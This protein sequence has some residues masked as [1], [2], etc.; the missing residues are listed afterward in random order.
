MKVFEEFILINLPKAYLEGYDIIE[1]SL[2]TK[3]LPLSPKVIFTS[4]G[5][6]RSTLMDRYIASKLLL[7]TKLIVAQHGGNYGQ[8]KGHWGSKHEM[9]ISNGQ[10][11]LVNYE[12]YTKYGFIKTNWCVILAL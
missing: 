11:A 1:N 7:N 2:K 9:K 8:H 3:N 12:Y 6:N 4:K 5:I 10:L